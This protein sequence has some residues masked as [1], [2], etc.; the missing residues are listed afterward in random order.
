MTKKRVIG[1]DILRILSMAGIVGLHV[2]NKGGIINNTSMHNSNYY[3]VLALAILF[4]TSVD[5]FGM[6]SGY[7]NIDKEK[8][9]HKRIVELISIVVFYCITIPTIYYLF[10]PS[11]FILSNYKDIISNYIPILKGSYWY[12][13]NYILLF[14]LIPYINKFCKSLSKEQYKKLLITLFIF[15]GI[16][17]NF[18][19]GKIDIFKIYYGYSAF[20]LI[21]CYLVGAYIKL[22]DINLETKKIIKYF[23]LLFIISFGINCI[24]KISFYVLTSKMID[25]EYLTGY[26]S[27]FTIFLSVLLVLLFKKITFTN[28]VLSKLII[29]LSSASFAV[30]IVHGQRAIFYTYFEGFF[31]PLAKYNL[32]YLM[33]GV[34]GAIVAIYIVCV[35]VDEIRILIYKLFR[36]D[37]FNEYIGKKL[38]N[39]IN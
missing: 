24:V 11:K 20:W 32:L 38:D 12:I 1:L 29:R 13:T 39:L 8:N 36:F 27:P 30:Y 21:C 26:I 14:F 3:I 6:L 18:F 4:F 37:K 2:L 5:V 15:L 22:Y 16:I 19:L 9:K 25:W 23:I 10:N 35:L 28:K 31:A 34:I 33:L 17:A 7:L